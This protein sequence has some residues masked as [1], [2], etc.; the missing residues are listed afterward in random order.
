MMSKDIL[1]RG[2][3]FGAL[4]VGMA[5]TA[6]I[7]QEAAAEAEQGQRSG[8]VTEIV[9]TATKRSADMQDIPVAVQAIGDKELDQLGVAVFDDYLAQL[10]GVTAG[11]GGPG[12]ST[13]YIRGLASTTPAVAKRRVLRHLVS[14][15]RLLL[16][17]L[18]QSRS[19]PAI[20][21]RQARI[22]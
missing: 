18:F 5:P 4:F 22:T 10:P 17:R 7:A 2:A 8:G 11:G 12:Q 3:A 20:T 21:V 16:I 1:L 15:S 13:I 9:V 6:A 14:R 19:Q